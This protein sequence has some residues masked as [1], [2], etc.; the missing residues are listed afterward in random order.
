M[1]WIRYVKHKHVPISAIRRRYV[2]MVP[3]FEASAIW[4]S[5]GSMRRH[6]LPFTGFPRGEFPSFF[7]TMRCYDSRPPFPPH[8][9]SFAWRYHPGTL[10]SLPSVRRAA[11][12]AGG[13]CSP[14]R[15]P[16]SGS[17]GGDDRASHVPGEP[18][19]CLCPALRPRQDRSHQAHTMR[20]RGPR[21]KQDEGSHEAY[22]GAQSHGLG[23]RCLR[24]AGWITPPPRKTRFWLL[25]RLY[26][27]GLLPAGFQRKVSELLTSS[28][29]P[30][31]SLVAQGSFRKMASAYCAGRS[32]AA[33]DLTRRVGRVRRPND[34][35]T[36]AIRGP[37]CSMQRRRMRN[38]ER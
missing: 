20:R 22:F 29:P 35:L 28:H 36:R 33:C 21:S 31:P 12:G 5:D 37:R 2:Q 25:A 15:L 8:F 4:P 9:V 6:P 11:P 27:T 34:G 10:A 14:L 17:K 1:P 23:T 18:P 16:P 19:L 3:E 7:G 24:F 26:Q 38:L 32:G 13:F 30:F